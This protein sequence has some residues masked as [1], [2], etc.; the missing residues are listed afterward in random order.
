MSATN[1]EHTLRRM[2]HDKEQLNRKDATKLKEMML[3]DGYLSRG[4]R[5]VIRNAMEKHLLDDTASEIIGDLL[6]RDQT[7]DPR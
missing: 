7:D 4:E 1:I 6:V 3:A 2:L 5:K